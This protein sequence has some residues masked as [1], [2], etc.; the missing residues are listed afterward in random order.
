MTNQERQLDE[1]G[2]PVKGR[3][4]R[5]NPPRPLNEARKQKFLEELT[6]HGIVGE[7]AKRASLHSHRGCLT[8]F[9]RERERD[10]DFAQAWDEA[11]EMARG[12]V[13]AELH[14]R[15]VEGYL[16]PIYYLGQEVG[17]VRK[18]SDSLLLARIRAV[19]PEY[20]QKQQIEHTG[21]VDIKPI[22]MQ[23]LTSSQRAALRELL[24][25]DEGKPARITIDDAPVVPLV[26]DSTLPADYGEEESQ[27]DED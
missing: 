1:N 3:G 18:Y 9:Y 5:P 26:G 21:G 8:S 25:G 20:R 16:E 6:K 7:A 27:A 17:E 12:A 15:A 23:S 19:A 22:D 24:Q 14:R 10:P 2:Y 4:Y 13:E 11:L